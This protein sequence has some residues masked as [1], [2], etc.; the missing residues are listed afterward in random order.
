MHSVSVCS[1]CAVFGV[2]SPCR[3][4][5][6]RCGQPLDP[7]GHHRAACAT[8]WVVGRRG[9]LLESCATRVCREAG[10]RVSTNLRVQDL[11]LLPVFQWTIVAL[12]WWQMA[13]RCST[14]HSWPSTPRWSA[15]SGQTVVQEGSAPPQT[16]QPSSKLAAGRNSDTPN[17]LVNKV[18]P[19]LWCFL[20]QLIG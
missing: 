8:S 7:R 10:A 5:S 1:C 13:C 19:D 4:L 11:D 17:S 6:A 20:R 3:P 16:E 2:L 18:V 9:H 14:G 15:Q 12:K